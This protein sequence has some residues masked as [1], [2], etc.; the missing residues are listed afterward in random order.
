VAINWLKNRFG[1]TYFKL[2]KFAELDQRREA[3]R[4]DWDILA[5]PYDVER[6]RQHYFRNDF[7]ELKLLMTTHDQLEAQQAKMMRDEYL[8]GLG[9]QLSEKASKKK[10]K[11][12]KSMQGDYVP[13]KAG[14]R[15]VS[16][17]KF[18]VQLDCHA[19]VLS[20]DDQTKK[21]L[22][23]KN[24]D[25]E[26]VPI[27][28]EFK[29]E[30]LRQILKEGVDRKYKI[31]YY[32][33]CQLFLEA[34]IIFLWILSLIMKSNIWSLVYLLMVFKYSCTRNKTNLMVRMCS[35][36]SVSLSIQYAIFMFNM[37]AQ[38]SP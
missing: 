38:S 27:L 33:G 6:Y 16:T 13:Y 14:R 32:K 18:C 1:C 35:Y 30:A 24:I 15:I 22:H 28:R 25:Y 9:G 11:Y 5:P 17:V 2:Q 19:K 10:S 8:R 29:I 36:L 4:Y 23:N 34:V 12:Q 31:S 21:C 37:T 20:L 7:D 26:S 3:L